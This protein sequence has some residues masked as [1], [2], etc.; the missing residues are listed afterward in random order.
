MKKIDASPETI[1]AVTRAFELA[2]LLDDRVAH[3]DKAS[4][5]AKAE[6]VER[7]KL[8]EPDL[9]DGVQMF[10][11]TPSDRPIQIGDV[12]HYGRLARQNRTSKEADAD[13]EQRRVVHDTKAAGFIHDISR[14]VSPPALSPGEPVNPTARLQAA[15]HRLQT[16]RGKYESIDAI[17]EYFAAKAAVNTSA[18]AA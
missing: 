15:K 17:R 8:Q 18:R 1:R 6:Q 3:P 16:C 7:H 12:I 9:L 11:D 2:C 5:A 14:Q 10:Y 13:R 4:I